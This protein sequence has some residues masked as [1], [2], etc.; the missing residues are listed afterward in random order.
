MANYT[1][2][3]MSDSHGN[4]SV[5]EE[6]KA[7]YQGQ[8]TGIFHNGDSELA[9]NLPVWEGIQVVRGNCDGEGYPD[10]LVTQFA[11]LTIA[12]THG[13]LYLINFMWDRLYFWAQEEGADICLYGHLHQATAWQE[14]K[15]VFINPG[16]VEQPRGPV[17]EKLYARV[18]VDD[19]R[20][21][22]DF[23]TLDHQLYPA[24]SKEFSR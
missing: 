16:S 10:R 24:L 17:Q 21:K 4:P 18:E 11:G 3:V 9:S 2:I 13:H 15:T 6:I 8:V 5:V 1:L 19:E 22:V 7:R 23:Y 12:Q 20:I 14:G